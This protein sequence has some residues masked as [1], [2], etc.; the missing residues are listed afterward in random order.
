MNEQKQLL[1]EKLI[2]FQKEIDS[3]KREKIELENSSKDKLEKANIKFIDLIDII[4]NIDNNFAEQNLENNET[5]KVLNNNI[6][7]IKKKIMRILKSY[8]IT[9]IDFPDNK[10]I[11]DFSKIIDTQ[12]NE[13][14]EDETIIDIIKNGYYNSKENKVIRKAELITV[15]NN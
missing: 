7:A 5:A 9:K 15:S 2:A 6:K 12:N 14:L 8:K 13:K 4:D 11:R 3:L 10:A 1:K